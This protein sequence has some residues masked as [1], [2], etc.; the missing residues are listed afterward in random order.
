MWMSDVRVICAVWGYARCLWF[1]CV[2]ACLFGLSVCFGKSVAPS[3][4]QCGVHSRPSVLY[5]TLSVLPFVNG[6]IHPL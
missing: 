6:T 2:F 3:C 1:V 4:L 5:F